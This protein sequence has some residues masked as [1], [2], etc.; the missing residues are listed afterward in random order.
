MDSRKRTLDES[1]K[2]IIA[3]NQQWKCK[4]CSCLLPSTYEIDHIVPFSISFDD[5]HD[6]LQALCPNCHRKKTQTENKRISSYKKL[7][8]IRKNDLC[9]FC[10]K[11]IVDNHTCNRICKAIKFKKKR[12]TQVH[13]LDSLIFTADNDYKILSI[14]LTPDAIW[15]DNFFTDMKGKH[16]LYNVEKIGRSVE[17]AHRMLKSQYDKVEVTIDFL[18][19]TDEE[20]S[21]E[22]IEHLD[23][24]LPDEIKK[25]PILKNQAT[26]EFTYIC[27][28]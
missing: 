19:F 10:L 16:E 12:R 11:P 26:A 1:D 14:K 27:I 9:W 25:V 21:P 13:T 7:C 8:S 18:S 3:F 6:N 15:V 28:D 24:Y 22:L 17:I 23:K 20:I 4:K 2:K 5:N